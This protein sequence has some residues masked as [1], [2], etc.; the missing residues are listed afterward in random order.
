M[1]MEKISQWLSVGANLG[2]LIGIVFLILEIRT[3]TDSNI[4]GMQ[5]T[6]SGNLVELNIAMAS[7]EFSEVI[8]KAR[9]GEELTNIENEQMT[10]IFRLYLT[11]ANYVRRLF[12]RG[13]VSEAEF[14][15]VWVP[16][17]GWAQEMD[18]V[19]QQGSAIPRGYRQLLL[20]ENGIESYLQSVK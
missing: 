8:Y 14:R 2:V 3:N 1:N 16:L 4:I 20:E 15:E 6:N 17:R 10:Y 11:Q 9:T 19:Q 12:E 18:W 5:Q 7:P 13:V